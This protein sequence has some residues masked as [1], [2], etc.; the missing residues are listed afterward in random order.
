MSAVVIGTDDFGA[1]AALILV[2][3]NAVVLLVSRE[4]RLPAGAAWAKGV[5]WRRRG[6][7]VAAAWVTMGV[8]A[9]VAAPALVLLDVVPLLGRSAD[10]TADAWLWAGLAVV[11]VGFLLEL[12]AVAA[13]DTAAW[14]WRPGDVTLRS[15][16][17]V[18]EG[19]YGFVRYPLLS[20]MATAQLG[21]V[22]MAASWVGVAGLVLLVLGCRLW[23]RRVEE[24]ALLELFGDRYLD[25]AGRV[26]RFVPFLGRLKPLSPSDSGAP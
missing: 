24:P 18:T 19:V 17:P 23:V 1:L 13:Q 16:Y 15:V 2:S 25:Y 22:V 9:G 20:G 5:P 8:L 26:G 4:A 6:F 21:T 7:P 12:A 10:W 3:G 14:P 11:T